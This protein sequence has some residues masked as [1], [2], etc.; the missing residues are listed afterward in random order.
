MSAWQMYLVGTIVSLENLLVG[1]G[2]IAGAIVFCI[3]FIKLNDI[4]RSDRNIPLKLCVLI[5]IISIFL[6]SEEVLLAI[7]E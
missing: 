3:S 2:L 7:F 4:E 1:I 5:I 6:P